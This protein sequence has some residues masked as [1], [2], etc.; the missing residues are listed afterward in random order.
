M[1]INQ[2]IHGFKL[3]SIKSIEDM[4]SKLYEFKHLKSNATCVFLE[5]DDTN[6][7]FAIGFRTLPQDSTGVCHIIEHSVLCG[8]E[9]YPL[10]EPFVNLIKGSMATFLNA[11]TANDWTMYPFASQT[12]KDFDNILGI[13]L[14]AVF[15]PISMKDPKPFLQEG[16]HLEMMD[17]DSIPSYKGVVYNE[18][19]GAMSSVEECLGQAT[20]KAMYKD[21]FYSVNSG[22]DPEVIPSL[23]YEQ[24][25]AFHAKH[26]T[27]ENA[28]TYFY[29]KMD[30]EPRLKFLDEE[31]FSKYEGGKD[32]IIV[33]EQTPF[34]NT[35]YEEDYEIGEGEDVK[36]NT[37]MS[38]A[39]A[40][41]KYDNVEEMTAFSVLCNAL[42]SS[43]ESPLKKT[44]LD[45]SLGQDVDVYLDDDKIRPALHVVLHKTNKS[46][47]E[48][49]RTVFVNAIKD[50]V[51]KG[52]DKELLLAS[53]NRL[54]FK[55][56]EMDMGRMAKGLIPAMQMMGSFNYRMPLESHL[57]FSKHYAKLREEL[58][59]G[60]F[61]KLL[62]KYILN[63]SHYVQVV[64]NPNATLGQEKKAAMDKKMLEL[65]KNM[66][67]EEIKAL[68]KQTKELIAYQN[69]VDTKKE[70]D[71]LPKLSLKDIPATINYLDT[72]KTKVNGT[73]CIYHKLDTNNIAYL[74]L[75]FN[76]KV[77]NFDDLPYLSLLS[78]LLGNVDTNKYDVQTLNKLV[79]MNLGDFRFATSIGSKSKEDYEINI[80][81]TISS[82]NENANVIPDLLNEVLL[83]SKFSA[84]VV[85][86]HVTQMAN[87]SKM[88]IMQNG[89]GDANTM[90]RSTSSKEGAIYAKAI[91][92]TN[93]H[94]FFKNLLENFD[95]KTIIA[96]LKEIS[97]KLFTK[98]NV[99]VSMS[100]NDETLEILKGVVKNIK[101]PRKEV[102]YVLNVE[103]NKESKKALTIPAGISYNS[104]GGNLEDV[105]E[106]LHGKLFVL[107]HIVTYDYL[108]NEVRVK[109]GAYGT[110]LRFFLSNDVVFGSY[111]DPNVENTYNVYKGIVDYLKNFKPSNDLFK[112]YLIG[113]VGGFDSPQSNPS[114]ID[115]WDGNYIMGITKK[116]KIEMKKQML[117]TS[118]QDISECA[119]IFE[120][121]LPNASMY[122]IGNEAKIKEYNVF[123]EVKSL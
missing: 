52:I 31:Y 61:E 112:S 7:C 115:S 119:G 40:L 122:T 72:K 29:G 84:K 23:T 44:L 94:E 91:H 110:G 26:Y 25:K 56:K 92:G 82:L 2:I 63:S 107:S 18:M 80:K 8:S 17:E 114:L 21:T 102:E 1:E 15:R 86:L 36:D 39:Y 73:S 60:Y 99:L 38:L 27:P 28:L 88:E 33:E 78:R 54:E 100:G 41:C 51:E 77:L 13:Y 49:F 87:E 111:R 109:G 95:A 98:K 66:S 43:N 10:K 14:D 85:K 65:K 123:D 105:G 70:L 19:K 118:K 5:N 62:E 59:K 90:V 121:V 69:R 67:K 101:L 24:Y 11:L 93:V 45:A 96:K 113:A 34:I 22:G 42:M 47:K 6:C 37:Y 103:L 4:N 79:K 12:P 50:L 75:Y 74:R 81:V 83:K 53:I 55:D 35:D 117:K 68:V 71:M 58:N 89:M 120:K 9:K 48:K 32:D 16:W 3:L 30:I 64:L 76:S 104:I 20:L 57:E 46:N 108:W 116:D 106:K 97:K